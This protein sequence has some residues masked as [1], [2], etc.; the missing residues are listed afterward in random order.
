MVALGIVDP[1]D[2]LHPTPL[3]DHVHQVLPGCV[4]SR[5]HLL[6][7][8]IFLEAGTNRT[9]SAERTALFTSSGLVGTMFSGFLQ[10]GVHESLVRESP[11]SSQSFEP[12]E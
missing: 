11:E 5:P 8:I 6:G 12:I 1:G 9:K 4:L 3:G 2:W 10:G 7:A